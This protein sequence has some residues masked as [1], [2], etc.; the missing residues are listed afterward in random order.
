MQ[1][2]RL[3]SAWDDATE[4]ARAVQSIFDA[5]VRF[6]VLS[7]TTQYSE[8]MFLGY[9]HEPSAIIAARIRNDATPETVVAAGPRV[10]YTWLGSAGG[11]RIDDI[12]GLT[13]GGTTYRFT[14]VM[15]G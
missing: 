8:P 6:E 13:P 4:L 14:F 3:K 15:I 5:L 10:C 7:V 1:P 12:N 2:L 11:L 9:D